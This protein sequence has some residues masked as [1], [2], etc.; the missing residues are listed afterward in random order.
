[1]CRQRIYKEAE[2]RGNHLWKD[3][4]N[5]IILETENRPTQNFP[6]YFPYI[7]YF[8]SYCRLKKIN[9]AFISRT[10]I[11]AQRRNT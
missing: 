3:E 8:S 2:E 11:I 5:N 1:M 7:L 6:W 9:F 10:E 4:W